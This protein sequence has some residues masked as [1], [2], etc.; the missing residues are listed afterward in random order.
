MRGNVSLFGGETMMMYMCMRSM[1]M[2]F[3]MCSGRELSVAD[4]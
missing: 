1:Q 4:C 2:F 3:G